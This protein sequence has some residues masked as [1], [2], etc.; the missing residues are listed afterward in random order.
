[1]NNKL[2]I[3]VSAYACEP[4]LGSEIG[5]GWHWVLEMSKY[6]ELWVLT[7]KSNQVGIEEWL[8][9]NP[10]YKNIRFIYFDLPY[11]L[12]FWKKGLRGVRTYYAIWQWCTNKIVKKS[13]KVNEITIFHHLTY[14]NAL[15]PVSNYGQKQFFIWGPTGGTETIPKDYSV[16]YNLKGRIIESLRR[17]V[18]KS[19]AFNFRF[20][21]R[22]KNANLMLCKTEE[23]K[24]NIPEVY[25]DK[26]VLF[27]DVAV[28]HFR[29]ENIGTKEFENSIKY[30]VVGRLDPWRGFDILIEAFAKAVRKN[31]N[32]QL[33][34]V[35]KGMDQKRLEKLIES[36]GMLTY[37]KMLGKVSL[38]EYKRLMQES[39][40]VVNPC[41]KEGAVTTAFDSMS[42]GKPLIC[43][44]TSGYTRYFSNEY[45]IV[46]P[47]LK[48]AE[49]ILSLTEAIL[50]LTNPLT[51]NHLGENAQRMGKK[52]TWENRGK[53]I[54]KTI[55]TNYNAWYSSD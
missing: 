34:I 8:E 14:G 22:C 28:D 11:Y 31:K 29:V 25:K 21:K 35:G 32:L 36:L 33:Q 16:H 39:D 42:L 46:I 1:M 24:E 7:R 55:T 12:R 9:E 38:D 10:S 17:L 50:N 19:L 20:K 26:A 2:K 23:H 4:Y 47:K 5:V 54:Y 43:L 15:L 6:F 18:V 53:D 49:T 30:I 48:R 27:T 37:I 52:F 41:L 13:M 51:R 3:F 40:I 44:D 45:A